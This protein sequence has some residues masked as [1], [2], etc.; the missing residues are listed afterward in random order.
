MDNGSP[1]QV[2]IN[3]SSRRGDPNDDEGTLNIDDLEADDIRA[4]E[5]F[6]KLSQF[7]S[8]ASYRYVC[9]ANCGIIFF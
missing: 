1:G 6:L 4:F 9:F 8:R 2:V 5:Q 7:F 3:G